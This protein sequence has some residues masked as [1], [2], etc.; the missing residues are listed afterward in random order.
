VIVIGRCPGRRWMLGIASTKKPALIGLPTQMTGSIVLSPSSYRTSRRAPRESKNMPL[1]A[2]GPLRSAVRPGSRMSR[3]RVRGKQ[4]VPPYGPASDSQKPP[5]VV[6]CNQQRPVAVPVDDGD[7]ASAGSQDDGRRSSS[8]SEGR[9]GRCGTEGRGRERN[10]GASGRGGRGR[11]DDKE[12]GNG[13]GGGEEAASHCTIQYYRAHVRVSFARGYEIGP[14]RGTNL[15][16]TGV[17]KRPK[18]VLYWRH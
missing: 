10:V 11:G 17:R 2:M 12:H 6:G 16:W 5:V 18:A 1:R 13:D 9:E 14:V 3:C 8:A 7:T 15:P 4:P